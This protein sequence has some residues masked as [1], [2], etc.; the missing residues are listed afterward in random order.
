MERFWIS[1]GWEVLFTR[2][3]NAYISEMQHTLQKGKFRVDLSSWTW[4]VL[5]FDLVNHSVLLNKLGHCW[6]AFAL[7]LL[8]LKDCDSRCSSYARKF[9]TSKR[10][11]RLFSRSVA[12][13]PNVLNC[14]KR[15]FA[16]ICYDEYLKHGMI[17]QKEAMRKWRCLM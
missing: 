6:I 3:L 10:L 8:K 13:S 2:L 11:Y 4:F 15:R 17:H 5:A 1:L 12:K 16:Q 9:L 7:S 14:F